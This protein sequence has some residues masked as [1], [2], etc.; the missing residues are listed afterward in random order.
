MV[1]QKQAAIFFFAYCADPPCVPVSKNRQRCPKDLLQLKV[2]QTG[3]HFVLHVVDLLQG[4][5]AKIRI[6]TPQ[7]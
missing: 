2:L 6:G 5:L 7:H 3:L 4:E 1:K